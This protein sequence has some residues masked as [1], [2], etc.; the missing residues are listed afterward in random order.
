MAQ[1]QQQQHITFRKATVQ[2]AVAM[3]AI[4]RKCL[5]ENYHLVEWQSILAF[6][7]SLSYVAMVNGKHVGYCLGI[8]EYVKDKTAS[9]A[10]IAVLPEYRGKKIGQSLL[11]KSFEAMR[12]MKIETVTLHV[13]ISNMTAQKLYYIMGFRKYKRVAKYYVNGED[14]Y[15]LKKDLTENDLDSTKI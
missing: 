13:R 15:I 8:L 10:S 12:L 6:M 14:A 5:P 1:Q 2:D 7:P 9:I 3:D 4:N 11:S